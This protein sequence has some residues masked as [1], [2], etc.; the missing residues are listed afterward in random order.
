MVR[1]VFRSKN[2][3]CVLAAMECR[4][5]KRVG[6][7]PL[8]TSDKGHWLP[9]PTPTIVFTKNQWGDVVSVTTLIYSIK[10]AVTVGEKEE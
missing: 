7:A 1:T 2:F 8:K 6:K 4:E 5:D 3:H 9:G 10:M